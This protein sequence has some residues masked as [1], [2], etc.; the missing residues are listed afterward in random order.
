[1]SA[2]GEFE[3]FVERLIPEIPYIFFTLAT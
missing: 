1:M 2:R 3:G